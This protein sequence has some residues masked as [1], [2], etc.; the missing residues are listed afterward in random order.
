MKKQL[1][2]LVMMLL[3]MVAMADDSGS[4]G[5][6]VT[7]TYVEATHTL[8]ISG[9]GPMKDYNYNDKPWN[10]Y[11]T[12]IVKVIIEEGVTTI[13]EN[14]FY[15]C[16]GLISI[17]IPN[18]VTSI[19]KNAFSNCS[20]LTSITI[21]NSVT[22][23]GDY[24]FSSCWRL[25]TITIPNSVTS[26][27]GG[28]FSHCSGLTSIII[29][30]SVTSIGVNTFN[31]CSGLTSI[32]IPYGVL[33]I[34]YSA[35][36][37]CSGLTSVTIPNSVTSIGEFAFDR[38]SGLTSITIPNSVTSISGSA[39][40]Y[41]SGLESI[42]VA[43]GNSTFNSENDCNAIIKT[44]THTL[45]AGC[46]N[47][48]IPN[49]VTS[50]GSSAFS[51]CRGLTSVTIPNSVTSIG[52]FAFSD[53]TGVISITI[54]NSVTS[55][56]RSAFS[57]CRGLTSV[58]IPN[59][60]TSIGDYAFLSCISLEMVKVMAATPPVAYGN[61]FNNYGIPLYVPDD[62]IETYTATSP[63]S[64]FTTIKGLSEVLKCAKPT[65]TIVDCKL[66]FECDTKGVKFKVNYNYVGTKDVEGD[67]TIL[68]G[69]TTCHVSV[70][71]TKEGYENS[72]VATADVE[73]HIGKKGDV[74]AD[75]E[76]NVADLVTTTN[77]IMGKDK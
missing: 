64:S 2:L 42:S 5:D 36:A 25:T 74:N 48:V 14:A 16:N 44:A 31:S 53:C 56:G 62:A 13:G 1:L 61:T 15:G 19:G 24:A 65:I 66:I 9:T 70:Y 59:S 43:N 50:I 54:S 20:G 47:T 60:V 4:C 58:T 72:D 18:S 63:W 39:F 26:I 52:E 76:V 8:T 27:G 17:T 77:I 75:G 10:N 45:I 38:C 46:K 41:C 12:T 40:A 21:P 32:T 22:S 34:G 55:I 73:L 6:N 3:P 28:A 69:T 68:A 67:E 57:G 30:N 7:Y 37:Y 23:I 35:F 11:G 51:G 49:S 71:A 33:S 29:P